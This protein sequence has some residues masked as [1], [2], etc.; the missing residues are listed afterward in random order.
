[1]LEAFCTTLFSIGGILYNIIFHRKHWKFFLSDRTAVFCE[2][3]QSAFRR[4]KSRGS[5]CRYPHRCKNKRW[6]ILVIFYLL[7]V[8][9]E[10]AWPLY[11][12]P[13]LKKKDLLHFKASVACALISARSIQTPTRGIPSATPCA[14]RCPPPEIRF[15]P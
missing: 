14:D 4:S 9:T 6:Y 15:G 2:A 11:R 3:V 5:E 10:N 8:T 1:M 7:D 12:M 13:G